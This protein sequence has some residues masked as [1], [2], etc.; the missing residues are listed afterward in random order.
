MGVRM[1]ENKM[2]GEEGVWGGEWEWMSVR[3]DEK[4][5]KEKMG[6]LQESK[7][8]RWASERDE[9]REQ[10]RERERKTGGIKEMGERVRWGLRYLSLHG[11]NKSLFVQVQ[12]LVLCLDK[13]TFRRPDSLPPVHI[14]ILSPDTYGACHRGNT[15]LPGQGQTDKCKMQPNIFQSRCFQ[16]LT[17]VLFL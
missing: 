6:A 1:R 7:K 10:Q 15:P 3:R 8:D 12:Y 9:H 5:R 16:I 14:H 17:I 13:P 2:M 4:E 11:G